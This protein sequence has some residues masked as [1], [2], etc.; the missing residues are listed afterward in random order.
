MQ[1]E[2]ANITVSSIDETIRFLSTVFPGA[3]VRGS[4]QMYWNEDRTEAR[5]R[6][7]HFGIDSHYVALQ[8]NFQPSGRED[9]TYRNDG[10]N[11]LG[12][13][14]SELDEIIRRANAAGYELSPASAMDAHPHRRRAYF[15]DGNNIEWE[16]V[17]YLSDEASERNDYQL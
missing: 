4:G 9:V 16:L 5:G 13:V 12:F 11:H 1:L 10:I 3:E 2:H 17:E 7:A 15:F 8:Q 6:W 14:V